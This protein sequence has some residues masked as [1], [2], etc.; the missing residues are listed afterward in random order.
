M[1]RCLNYRRIKERLFAH[2]KPEGFA[3]MNADDPA[4]KYLIANVDRP[5]ITIGMQG[6]AEVTAEPLE[7]HHG[8]QTFLLTAGDETMP[9]CTSVIGRAHI[10]NCL[11][12]AA[13][14]LVLGI[15]PD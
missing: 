7:Y 9:V 3:V 10:Y 8:E 5:L 14:G 13:V 2:L 11:S 1:G 4:S 12:A 6:D 15:R